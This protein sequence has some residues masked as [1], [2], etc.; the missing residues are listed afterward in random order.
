MEQ[1]TL[2]QMLLEDFSQERVALVEDMHPAD[3]AE[4]LIEVPLENQIRFIDTL[5]NDLAAMILQEMELN[6]EAEILS[7][8]APEKTAKILNQMYTDEAADLLAELPE[9]EAWA[10][11][12]LMGDKGK[13]V[14]KLLA[15]E[16]DTSGGLMATEFIAVYEN[17]TL[18]Q[19]LVLLREKA[20][21]TESAYYIYV[22]SQ[23]QRLVGVVSLRTLVTKPL[24]T[25]VGDVMEQDV[26]SAPVDLDQEEVARLFDKYGFLVLPV[27]DQA[28]RLLGV[29][30]VDDVL[31]VAEEEVTEDIHKAAS[32][33]PMKEAYIDASIWTLFGKRIIWLLGLILVNLV[34]S[35]V[36]AA[37]EDILSSVIALTFFIP[38]L[39]DTGGNTGSQSATMVV[40]AL[41]TG[42]VK[43]ADW[44]KV[45]IK[46]LL[47]GIFLGLVL[48]F[49][50]VFLGTA[51]GGTE[52]GLVVGLTMVAIVI[53]SNI[54][55][56]ALP[57][58]LTKMRL[59]PAVASSPLITSICDATGLLIYFAIATRVFK[60]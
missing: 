51:R 42:D 33:L 2:K 34:S 53:F 25:V 14:K 46:E 49:A 7:H 41:V 39:I 9:T 28:Q 17:Q 1:I 11:I 18:E 24:E 20:P 22:V 38:L 30:T 52:V 59:D 5:P 37:Y 16:S 19:V 35:G 21:S 57:F 44:G 27:V 56:M 55:G 47:V 45:L 54:I 31:G 40:R 8:L 6:N 10:L 50:G 32:I 4:I 15:Y 13:K 23:E 26:I 48:G 60:F 36:I 3:V 43:M 58:I 29:I 12:A